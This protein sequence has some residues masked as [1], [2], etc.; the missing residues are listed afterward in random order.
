M[1]CFGF[2][3]GAE[4]GKRPERRRAGWQSTQNGSQQDSPADSLDLVVPTESDD[5]I[6]RILRNLLI[7]TY[8]KPL[9]QRRHETIRVRCLE[10]AANPP[11]CNYWIGN[12]QMFAVVAVEF[13]RDLREGFALE[14]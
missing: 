9:L 7:S 14:G 1:S 2:G 11:L 3:S 13:I 8:S 12:D 6:P 5:R 10:G 4:R